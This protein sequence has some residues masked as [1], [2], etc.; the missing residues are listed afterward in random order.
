MKNV[1]CTDYLCLYWWVEA[2]LR[3]EANSPVVL[4]IFDP[5]HGEEIRALRPLSSSVSLLSWE[6]NKKHSGFNQISH[7]WN[8]SI[9][10]WNYFTQTWF[11]Q[12]TLL[13][14]NA[15]NLIISFLET[16]WK[17]SIIIFLYINTALLFWQVVMVI[18]C[19]TVSQLD[20]YFGWLLVHSLHRCEE[21]L[22]WEELK[23]SPVQAK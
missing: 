1:F 11:R 9:Q 21:C 2:D 7:W 5:G 4:R 19:G 12:V 20:S 16:S 23:T 13:W 6:K 3:S 8:F 14:R 17:V 10:W 22:V 15:T 18:T